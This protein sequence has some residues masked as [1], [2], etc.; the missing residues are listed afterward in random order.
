MPDLRYGLIDAFPSA[1]A[2][3]IFAHIFSRFSLLPFHHFPIFALR[4]F[5]FHIF[6]ADH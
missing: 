6:F 5:A 3:S 4:F 2:L 1:D